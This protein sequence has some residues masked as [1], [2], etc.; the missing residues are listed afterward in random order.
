M[1]R[2]VKA[3]YVAV[4]RAAPPTDLNSLGEPGEARGNIS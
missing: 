4:V 1:R 3:A 2:L